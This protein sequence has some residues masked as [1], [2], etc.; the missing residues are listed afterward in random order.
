MGCSIVITLLSSCEV[1]EEK[2]LYRY[3]KGR[4]RESRVMDLCRRLLLLCW[5]SWEIDCGGRE[6]RVEVRDG[7]SWRN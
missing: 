7:T 4:R 5:V 2:V 1:S 6:V 3:W